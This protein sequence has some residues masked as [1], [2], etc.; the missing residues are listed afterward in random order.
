M[1][2]FSNKSQMMSKCSKN[3][4]LAHK[5]QGSVSSVIILPQPAEQTSYQCELTLQSLDL[6]SNWPC[7]IWSQGVGQNLPSPTLPLFL[8]LTDDAPPWY[9]FLSLFSLPPQLKSKMLATITTAL[10]AK[11]Y[12]ILTS[13]EIFCIINPQQNE[14]YL[15]YIIIK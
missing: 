15:F 8:F 9:K 14:I 5:A 1:H 12:Q 10:Q 13:S 11:S 7:L 6:L 2:L 4:K 3:K